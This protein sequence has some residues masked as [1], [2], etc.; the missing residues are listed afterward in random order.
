MR[1]NNK[2]GVTHLNESLTDAGQH[3]DGRSVHARRRPLMARA[4]GERKAL[5]GRAIYRRDEQIA[6]TGARWR[7]GRSM[8]APDAHYQV[9]ARTGRPS[10]SSNTR[11]I[12]MAR[13]IQLRD[14]MTL[15]RRLLLSALKRDRTR[16][17][18][19]I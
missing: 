5:P 11:G 6:K 19:P 15:V 8:D 4:P 12:T 1:A 18:P 2:L 16:V 7:L 13:S 9:P 14:E 10:S 17:F 3:D